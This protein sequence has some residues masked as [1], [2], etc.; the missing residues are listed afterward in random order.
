MTTPYLGEIRLMPYTYAPNGWNDCDGSLLSIAEYD[1]L[2][3]LI[4]TAF[5][6]DG[7][8][9]FALPDM[10][11]RLPIHNGTGNG[12]STYVLGQRAGNESVT[13]TPQQLAGHTHAMSAT[14]A[15]ASTGVPSGSVELGSISG[16]ALYT[17]S[18]TGLTAINIANTMVSFA[19][20]NQ[21]HENRMPTLTMRFCIALYGVYPSQS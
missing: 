8:Q 7:V 10:R 21:P 3:S 1:S 15:G 18:I 2:Y 17:N 19:G 11:G 13:L 4:G 16:D 14:T 12:L 9:T 5:G 20:G 6:G